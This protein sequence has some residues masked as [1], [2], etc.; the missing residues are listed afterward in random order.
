[1]KLIA[2]LIF[3]AII[4]SCNGDKDEKSSDLKKQANENQKQTRA[5]HDKNNSKPRQDKSDEQ[6]FVNMTDS[7]IADYLKNLASVSRLAPNSQESTKFIAGLKQLLLRKSPEFYEILKV[8]PPGYFSEMIVQQVFLEGNLEVQG[9]LAT[10][11]NINQDD[12]S[13]AALNGGV[14]SL[15]VNGEKDLKIDTAVLESLKKQGLSDQNLSALVTMG[16]QSGEYSLN[17]VARY[18]SDKNNSIINSM[19]RILS[20]DQLRELT[21]L[22][23]Q[24]GHKLDRTSLKVM[25]HVFAQADGGEALSWAQKLPQQEGEQAAAA[26]F[27]EWMDGDPLA[28]SA[29]LNQMDKGR[30]RDVSTL[31]LVK[32]CIKNKGLEDAKSWATHIDDEELKAQALDII[33]KY[34]QAISKQP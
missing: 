8:L 7:E 32:N 25:A 5:A 6:L 22:A 11:K 33:A 15:L 34:Q 28:A 27:T 9:L 10:V 18:I 24:N 17:D 19:S 30:I 4:V 13:K 23:Y 16:Y 31:A 29:Y 14:S 26:I 12:L 21:L 3:I 1:M 2:N 20:M